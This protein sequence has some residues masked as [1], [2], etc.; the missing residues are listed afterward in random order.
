MKYTLPKPYLSPSQIW[1]YLS[2]GIAYWFNYIEKVFKQ[3]DTNM[4]V[5]TAVH[6]AIEMYYQIVIDQQFAA[7]V[8]KMVDYAVEQFS[9][10]SEDEGVKVA[11]EDKDFAATAITRVTDSYIKHV[12]PTIIPISTEENVE[13]VSECGVP[14]KGKLDLRRRP[15][16]WEKELYPDL[17]QVIADHKVGAVWSLSKLQN[18]LQFVLYS[19]ATG[20]PRVEIHNLKRD[21]KGV[22]ANK[23]TPAKAREDVV[24]PASNIRLLRSD[25]DAVDYSYAEDMIE[26]VAANISAGNFMPCSPDSWTCTPVKCS[27]WN[28]CRGLGGVPK[29][30][31]SRFRGIVGVPKAA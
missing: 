2:C 19:K 22:R 28:R 10:I 8:N 1:L 18:S 20:V 26:R 12:A 15:H 29:E 17:D 13:Y 16:D 4:R 25:F 21:I 27:Y 24:E 9:E 7:P 31:C 6:A 3:S 11:G 23:I 30:A 5:G 14:I